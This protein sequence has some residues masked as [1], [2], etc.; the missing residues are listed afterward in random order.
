MQKVIFKEWV[1]HVHCL[2][3]IWAWRASFELIAGQF[4]NSKMFF[5]PKGSLWWFIFLHS[6][7]HGTLTNASLLGPIILS[8]TGAHSEYVTLRTPWRHIRSNL[9]HNLLSLS[10]AGHLFKQLT[11]QN[12]GD[13]KN[14]FFVPVGEDFLWY[15]HMTIRHVKYDITAEILG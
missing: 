13:G 3:F 14:L 9:V 10:V 8:F 1:Y 12:N 15:C 6:L 4:I 7:A 11:L 2:Q 5:K